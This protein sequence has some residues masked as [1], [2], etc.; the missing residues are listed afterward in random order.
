MGSYML[1]PEK[2]CCLFFLLIKKT[3]CDHLKD[4]W[5]LV[6]Y[7][8]WHLSLFLQ[9]VLPTEQIVCYSEWVCVSFV[10]FLNTC[11]KSSINLQMTW[12][13]LKQISA[14]L[15]WLCSVIGAG[16]SIE[17]SYLYLN[18]IMNMKIKFPRFVQPCKQMCTL[19][20]RPRHAFEP[21]FMLHRMLLMIWAGTLYDDNPQSFCNL[22]LIVYLKWAG[23]FWRRFVLLARLT[24]AGDLLTKRWLVYLLSHSIIVYYNYYECVSNQHFGDWEFGGLILFSLEQL[25]MMHKYKPSHEDWWNPAGD[26]KLFL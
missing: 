9:W 14:A 20:L 15:G 3:N 5:H 21:N 19:T 26:C 23:M 18:L 25:W 6:H 16:V 12:K 22:L 24:D 10:M 7:M 2:K 17:S 4:S 8:T 11:R 1:K 13:S